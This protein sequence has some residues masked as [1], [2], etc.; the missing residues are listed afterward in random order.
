[1]ETT[2]V[3]SK[4]KEFLPTDYPELT[5]TAARNR[6]PRSP[7]PP[8]PGRL[9]LSDLSEISELSRFSWRSKPSTTKVSG[10]GTTEAPFEIP[11]SPNLPPTPSR[12][13]S[14]DDGLDLGLSW[15]E[16]P[17][18]LG[19]N[20]AEG[21][22]KEGGEDEKKEYWETATSPHELSSSPTLAPTPT[23]GGKLRQLPRS[24][25]APAPLT[26]SLAPPTPAARRIIQGKGSP[27]ESNTKDTY[28][29]YHDIGAIIS[30][31]PVNEDDSQEE[32]ILL[33][34]VRAGF[35]AKTNTANTIVICKSHTEANR[36]GR[37]FDNDKWIALV[38]PRVGKIWLFR[39]PH[40]R[41][42]IGGRRPAAKC[43]ICEGVI[44][45]GKVAH[46][47]VY[48][49]ETVID[50]GDTEPVPGKVKKVRFAQVVGVSEAS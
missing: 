21:E 45:E 47:C 38:H 4:A 23:H 22:G 24:S 15:A 14:V 16:M 26:S 6:P 29:Y 7:F 13:T 11:G 8:Y 1:M 44:P 36:L 12:C 18:L 49:R 27:L 20:I 48:T 39:I 43:G 34:E 46:G 19:I 35:V 50:G 41:L 28:I 30:R 40:V 31:D 32:I 2:S 42:L 3:K 25:E 10:A 37:S 17:E 9:K 33:V 5:A